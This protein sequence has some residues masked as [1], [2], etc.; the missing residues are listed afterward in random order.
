MLIIANK[1]PTIRQCCLHQGKYVSSHMLRTHI[2]SLMKAALP[3]L[4]T[5]IRNY[6]RLTYHLPTFNTHKRYAGTPLFAKGVSPRGEGDRD[7]NIK[8]F[9]PTFPCS[10]KTSPATPPPPA[11]M[12]SQKEDFFCLL[13]RWGRVPIKKK[14]MNSTPQIK[15]YNNSMLLL[16]PLFSC[17]FEN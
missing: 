14:T 17:L 10:W 5:F 2:F 7:Q 15:V 3:K 6:Q 11:N 13:S 4:W 12:D 9:H 1:T 16:T 8:T